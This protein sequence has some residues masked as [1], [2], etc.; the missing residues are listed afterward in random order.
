MMLINAIKVDF[1]RN[2]DTSISIS[3]LYARLKNREDRHLVDSV[4]IA[5]KGIPFVVTTLRY[6]VGDDLV[7][8]GYNVQDSLLYTITV[9]DILVC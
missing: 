3:A 7:L 6:V 1:T 5:I 9:K 8:N 4:E 2:N